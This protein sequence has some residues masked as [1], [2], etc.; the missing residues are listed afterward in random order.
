MALLRGD[1]AKAPE[2]TEAPAVETIEPK[3]HTVH[4]HAYS[5]DLPPDSSFFR[6]IRFRLTATY[7]VLL[8]VI[9]VALGIVLRVL[10][11]R[12]LENDVNQR[13]LSVAQNIEAN[14]RIE[15][16]PQPGESSI[17]PP[18]KDAYVLAGFQVG[19]IDTTF[20]SPDSATPSYSF[21]SD[22]TSF[23]DPTSTLS[24]I[25]YDSVY[26]NRRAEV[27]QIT[28]R[29]NPYRV[30]VY[31]FDPLQSGNVSGIIVVGQS[32]TSFAKTTSLLNQVLLFVGAVGVILAVIAGW[33]VAGRALSPVG[34]ITRTADEIAEDQ[35]DVMLSKRL[36]VSR[37]GDELSQLALTFNA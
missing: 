3:T 20:T 4:P 34:R 5:S 8:I 15:L 12:N 17:V 10:L 35:Y 9:L 14:T 31:P 16:N 1:P 25:D 36:V 21:L 13:L 32:S 22:Y 24:Q 29:N 33:W 11:T 6:S 18:S 7:A 30:V 2:T 28:V 19:I 27:Q 23:P 26:T 37:A